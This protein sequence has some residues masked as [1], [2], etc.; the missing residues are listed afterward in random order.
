MLVSTICKN[1]INLKKEHIDHLLNALKTKYTISVDWNGT[2]YCGLT[3]K[4]N[5]V[6]GYIDVSMPGYIP[7]LL[8]RI[9][10]KPKFL[11]THRIE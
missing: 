4:Q 2:K 6:L 8:G 3:L 7:R 5:Y 10:Y 1:G 11:H 9:N